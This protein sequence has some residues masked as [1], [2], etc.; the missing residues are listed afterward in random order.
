MTSKPQISKLELFN[1]LVTEL[2]DQGLLNHTKLVG[3]T[4]SDQSVTGIVL[5][6][7]LKRWRLV[8]YW[9]DPLLRFKMEGKEGERGKE[10]GR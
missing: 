10:R 7:G 2:F 1:F 3:F 9:H 8:S 5:C 4:E 6:L